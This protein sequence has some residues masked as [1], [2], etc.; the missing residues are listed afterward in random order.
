MNLFGWSAF[1]AGNLRR[2]ITWRGNNLSDCPLNMYIE[3]KS[4]NRALQVPI[5]YLRV[6][7]KKFTYTTV[8]SIVKVTGGSYLDKFAR[9]EFNLGYLLSK[10]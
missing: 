9:Q 10:E 7:T 2:S 8:L 1:K 5:S 6:S 3:D 4:F